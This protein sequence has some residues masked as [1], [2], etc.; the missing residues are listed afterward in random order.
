MNYFNLSCWFS[1]W[2]NGINPCMG[3][4]R[5]MTL[6]VCGSDSSIKLNWIFQIGRE[7]VDTIKLNFFLTLLNVRMLADKIYIMTSTYHVLK[8]PF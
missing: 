2:G 3:I 5:H 6:C 8:M 7:G 4:S 1:F